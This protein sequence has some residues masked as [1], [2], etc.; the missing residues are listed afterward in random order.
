L[1]EQQNRRLRF[2]VSPLISGAD[3]G[4]V[5][6]FAV[7]EEE[8]VFFVASSSFNRTTKAK[9]QCCCSFSV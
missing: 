1:R 5:A 4:F 6:D 9:N 7:V 2:I 3:Y 8:G